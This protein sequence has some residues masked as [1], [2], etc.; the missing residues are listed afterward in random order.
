MALNIEIKRTLDGSDT[1]FVPAIKE[2]YHSIFGA[3]QESRH[4]FIEQ[5]LLAVSEDIDPVSV[6]EVGFGTG[7]NA[8]LTDLTAKSHR[9]EVRYTTIELYPLDRTVWGTLNYPAYLPETDAAERFNKIHEAPWEVPQQMNQGFHLT[10]IQ[11]DL[12]Q[13]TPPDSAF[14]V[15]FFDAFA[16]GVQPDLWTKEIFER[17]YRMLHPGGL[18]VTY[19]CQG[20]VKRNLRY[21]GFSIEKLPGP[22]GKREILRAGKN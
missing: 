20:E 11:A 6:F 5:G 9:R 3:V 22:P 19:S 14:D 2:H 16:P 15:V 7:L 12:R 8:L 10:K 17:M 1:L 21:A 13:Y 18:L 4:V